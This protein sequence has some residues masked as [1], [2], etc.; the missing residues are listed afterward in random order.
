MRNDIET[1]DDLLNFRVLAKISANFIESSESEPLSIGISGNWGTGK[2]SLIKMVRT[3]LEASESSDKY[4]FLEFNAWLYQGYEDAKIALL[5]KVA[6]LLLR[7]SETQKNCVD[8]AKDFIKR[9]QWL[10]AVKVIL[11]AGA[12]FLTG[13]LDGGLVASFLATATATFEKGKQVSQE[14]IDQLSKSFKAIQPELSTILKNKENISVPQEIEDIRTLFKE[15]LDS[16]N[17]KLIIMVDDLDRCLPSTAISTLEAMRL[18]LF[19][20]NTAFIIAADEQ[21]IRNAVRFHFGIDDLDS[22]LITSYFDKLIQIPMRVPRLG[23]NEVKVYVMLLLS[24][25]AFKQNRITMEEKREAKE[26]L[27][28]YLEQSW[29]ANISK[30]IL[31]KAFTKSQ[32]KLA[33][34]IDIADQISAILTTSNR[35]AGNPRLIKRFLNN[36]LIRDLMAKSQKMSISFEELV[37]IQLFERC[38]LNRDFE[39]LMKD[40]SSDSNGHSKILKNIEDNIEKDQDYDCPNDDWKSGF[41]ADW[42]K[43]KPKLG[44]IDLRPLLYLS[45]DGG[46]SIVRTDELSPE[47]KEAFNAICKLKDYSAVINSSISELGEEEANKVMTKLIRQARS[48]QWDIVSI[49]QALVIPKVYQNLAI[50]FISMLNE[51]PKDKRNSAIIPLIVNEDWAQALLDKW[52]SEDPSGKI[53]RAIEKG[54][55]K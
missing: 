12:A 21:M 48:Q 4:I 13:G 33:K 26:A 20:P 18:L 34:E 49:K 39:I 32:Q 15:L 1:N 7:E 27:L 50:H 40:V 9:I 11:P 55:R 28:K 54:R 29:S 42:L 22:D 8:K 53:A 36:L 44:N 10:K 45:K 51:I 3:E 6:D 23:N 2:S 30:D 25:L 52:S 41:I 35:I 14:E 16:L 31:E 46:S 43:L 19:I 24:E 17:L 37:K 47:G 38:A 5:Q